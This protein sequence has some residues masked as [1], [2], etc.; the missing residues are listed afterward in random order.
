MR[1][2]FCLSIIALVVLGMLG[3]GS[4]LMA[5]PSAEEMLLQAAGGLVG[6]V[7]GGF[8]GM[9][10]S[11]PSVLSTLPECP[12]A[13]VALNP[14]QEMSGEEFQAVFF[15]LIGMMPPLMSF[16]MVTAAGSALGTLAGISWVGRLQGVQGST[17]GAAIGILAGNSVMM[18]LTSRALAADFERIRASLKAGDQKSPVPAGPMV[19][20]RIQ[21]IFLASSLL[22]V[23]G[24]VIGYNW[25]A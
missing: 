19:A 20:L 10:T 1:I 14:G 4:D 18:Y 15:C 9:M 7:V 2:G 8:L 21:A 16:T 3:G 25:G 11:L 5:A 23:I 17:L 6:Q 12:Q 24:G 13:F 22:P